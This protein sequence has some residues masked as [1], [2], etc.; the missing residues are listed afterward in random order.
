LNGYN[1]WREHIRKTIDEWCS[2]VAR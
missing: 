1:Q 2:A